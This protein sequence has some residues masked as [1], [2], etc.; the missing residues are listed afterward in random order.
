VRKQLVRTVESALADDDRVILLLGDIGVFGFR[1]AFQRFPHRV[2]NIGILEQATISM[3]AGLALEGFTPIFHSIAPFTVERAFE[4]IKVDFGYQQLPGL[5]ISVG[6]SYDYAALGCTHHSPGD[7]ALLRTVPGVQI[8]VPGSPGE[9]DQLFRETYKSGRVVY[10]RLSEQTHGVPVPPVSFGRAALIKQGRSGAVVTVG[11]L[12][13]SVLAA[14]QDLDVSV[15]YY[16]TVEPFDK[17][18]LLQNCPT[19]KIALVEPFYEGTL[20]HDILSAMAG[21]RAVR[22]LSIGVPRRFLRSYGTAAEH[23]D[24]NGLT[25]HAIHAKLTDFLADS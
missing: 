22:V 20:S 5:I 11:P 15:L 24:D 25:A 17:N 9:F 19:D 21:H 4:Q 3:A 10:F 18:T 12:L 16:S 13:G 2:Y 8:V 23:N 1:N 14:C 6:A 7:V